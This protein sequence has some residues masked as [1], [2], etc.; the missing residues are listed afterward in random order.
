MILGSLVCSMRI[1]EEICVS[2]EISEIVGKTKCKLQPKRLEKTKM[3]AFGKYIGTYIKSII[4]I[5]T[6]VYNNINFE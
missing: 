4:Y 1:C 3:I 2:Q 6:Y 5:P